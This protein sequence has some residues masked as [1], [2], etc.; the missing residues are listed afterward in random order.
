LK[1]YLAGLPRIQSGNTLSEHERLIWE[2]Y[3]L[4]KL[5]DKD[6][7]SR[8]DMNKR[9]Y[10]HLEELLSKIQALLLAIPAIISKTYFKHA[11]TQTQLFATDNN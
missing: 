8:P 5:S 2:A 6:L 9:V 7:L 1:T 11:Q 3:T 4:L 10:I